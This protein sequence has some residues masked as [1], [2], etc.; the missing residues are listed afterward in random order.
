[1]NNRSKTF[2]ITT[3]LVIIMGGFFFS[4]QEWTNNQVE[5]KAQSSFEESVRTISVSGTGEI[6]TQPDLAIIDLGVTTEAESAQTALD[7][8]NTKTQALIDALDGAGIPEE[9]IQTQTFQ[10]SPNTSYDNE[11]DSQTLMGYSVSNI[12]QVTTSDLDALGELLDL[13]VD[14]GVNTIQNIRYDV[15]D[16]QSIA[17]QARQAAVEDARSKAEQLAS[18]TGATLGPVMNIEENSASPVPVEQP[19]VAAETASVPIEPG[20]YRLNIS[21]NI[22]WK[23]IDSTTPI[24]DRPNVRISPQRGKPGTMVQVDATGFPPTTKVEIGVGHW[25]SE[26]IVVQSLQTDRQGTLSAQVEIPNTANVNEEWVVVVAEESIKPDRL[27]VSSNR[28][29]VTN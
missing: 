24:S 3:I 15:S 8:N 6:Q 22:T 12:I 17:V 16:P 20:N 29:T 25:G 14:A 5:V 13:A 7:E 9:N 19:A 11:S 26:Y 2:L 18:L 27:K 21:L 10:L 23:L 1:M 28:F 4:T